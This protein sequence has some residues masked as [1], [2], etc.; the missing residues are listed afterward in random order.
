MKYKS[1]AVKSNPAI[2]TPQRNVSDDFLLLKSILDFWGIGAG[3]IFFV[4]GAIDMRGNC[5]RGSL[6]DYWLGVNCPR[7]NCPG[8]TVLEP[9]S[10]IFLEVKTTRQ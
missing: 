1:R 10:P 5:P 7:G 3:I 4:G 8:G 2:K 6:R 9:Y